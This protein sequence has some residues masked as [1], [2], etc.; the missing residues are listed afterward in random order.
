MSVLPTARPASLHAPAATHALYS[1]FLTSYLSISKFPTLTVRWGS[2]NQFAS[3]IAPVC[4]PSVALHSA[5]VAAKSAS[6]LPIV[7][8]PPGT[9]SHAM[10]GGVAFR[11]VA[12]GLGSDVD[13]GSG[14]AVGSTVGVAS[15]VAFVPSVGVGS[16]ENVGA[17][18]AVAPA[19]DAGTTSAGGVARC[20]L[21]PDFGAAVL[22]PP[23]IVGAG[24]VRWV[25]GVSG[26]VAPAAAGAV[27]VWAATSVTRGRLGVGAGSVRGAMRGQITAADARTTIKAANG[28]RR[29]QRSAGRER[30]SAR[31]ASTV[32]GTPSGRNGIR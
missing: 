9:G 20:P 17:T 15:T 14:V 28:A 25:V 3:H 10:G 4:W 22:T 11:G 21:A 16:G 30:G 29:R 27:T 19:A 32:A 7:N 12:V 31:V 26:N 5:S 2:L 24:R 1:A 8:S 13:V 18:G 23:R 6:L